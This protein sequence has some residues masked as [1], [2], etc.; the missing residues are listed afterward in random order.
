MERY[1]W[2]R[3]YN[4]GARVH[5]VITYGVVRHPRTGSLRLAQHKN[6][7][8]TGFVRATPVIFYYNN[9]INNVYPFYECAR[10]RLGRQLS[11]DGDDVPRRGL[12]WN[13]S[14]F[15]S[16]KVTRVGTCALAGARPS[17]V[18]NTDLRASRFRDLQGRLR[19][20]I[21]GGGQNNYEFKMAFPSSDPIAAPP[22]RN[23]ARGRIT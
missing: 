17:G 2:R 9:N 16:R 3:P 10:V 8:A 6:A 7:T 15:V 12:Q 1:E 23:V 14:L 11:R 4:V 22:A 20:S 13:F 21:M 18:T 5:G 19:T